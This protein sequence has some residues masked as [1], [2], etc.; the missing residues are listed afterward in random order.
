M[1]KLARSYHLDILRIIAIFSV[2]LMHTAGHT[3][4]FFQNSPQTFTYQFL[5][6]FDTATRF[7]V[8]VFVMISGALFLDSNKVLSTKKLYRKNILRLVIAFFFWSLI[9]VLFYWFLVFIGYH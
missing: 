9:Y 1:Q 6:I 7:A 8:P 2:L 3:S 4:S 5:S